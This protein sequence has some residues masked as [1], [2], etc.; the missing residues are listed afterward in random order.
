MSVRRVPAREGPGLGRIKVSTLDQGNMFGKK[1]RRVVKVSG[2]L[3]STI[4]PVEER[5]QEAA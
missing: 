5:S 4:P 2:R 3:V 1:K